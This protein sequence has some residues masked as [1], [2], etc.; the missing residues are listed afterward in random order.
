[1]PNKEFEHLIMIFE[2]ER[3]N[4]NNFFDHKMEKTTIN[5]MDAH[6]HAHIQL[7]ASATA[8]ENEWRFAHQSSS[9]YQWDAHRTYECRTFCAIEPDCNGNRVISNSMWIAV[10]KRAKSRSNGI[11][12]WY[13]VAFCP[14]SFA[15]IVS[16]PN[17][18]G[19]C[20]FP[21]SIVVA[22]VAAVISFDL[23]WTGH[24]IDQQRHIAPQAICV[25]KRKWIK[26]TLFAGKERNFSYYIHWVASLA[27]Q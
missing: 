27:N 14:V 11:P 17:W 16:I 26:V 18:F 6:A 2:R 22:A 12:L 23:Y 9:S 4:K 1:M 24:W 5:R 8:Y 20:F 13:R 3:G 15:S 25:R 7:C 19:H 10:C 21:S